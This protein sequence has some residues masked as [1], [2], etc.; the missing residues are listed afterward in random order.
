MSDAYMPGIKSRFNTDQI[1]ENLMKIE[2]V[3]RDRAQTTVDTL[4]T[5]KGYWQDVGK[6]AI[7]LRD[8][9]RQLYSYQNPFSDRIVTS[10]DESILTGTAIRDATEQERTFTVK[11]TAE[12]DRFLS[13]PLEQNFKVDSGS[14]TFTVGKEEISFEFR[15]GTLKE[16]TDALNRRGRD[17]LQSSLVTVKPGTTS[18][19]IESKLTGEENRL[20][21]SGAASA[22]GEKTGMI[23]RVNDSRK[24]FTNDIIKV[25]SGASSE[26]PMN[27]QIPPGG[28]WVLKFETATEIKPEDPWTPPKPPP[29]PSIPAAGYISYGGI[30][31]ENDNSSVTLPPWTAPDPPKHVDNMGVLSLT[32]SDGS[33]VDLPPISDSLGF[34]GYQYSL[35]SLAGRSATGGAGS[36][37]TSGIGGNAISGAGSGVNSD[38]PKTIVSMSI[39]NNNTNRDIN[40]R[41]VQVFDPNALGGIKPLNP[42][43]TAQD[44]IVS[45]EGIEVHR[46][47]NNIS[48]LI[49]GVTIT[50]KTASDTPVKLKVEPDRQ[51]AKDNI[52][53]FV[54]NYNRLI[55]EINVLTRN[56]S[57]IIEELTYLTKDEKDDYQKKLGSFAGDSTLMQIRS[58]LMRIV[59]SP[60]PTSEEQNLSMLAQI[61]IGTDV[62]RSG[63]SGG[64]DASRLR[65]YLEIDEKALD[66]ALANQMPAIKELFASD[67]SG[68]LLPDTGIAYSVDALTKP[69]V[70]SNGIIALK[71]GTM[72]T[73]IAQQK[74]TID[75]LDRQ[76]TAKEADLKKQYSQ[77]ESAYDRMQ[78]M[79]TSLDRFQQQNSNT[80]N[81]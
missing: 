48:D 74:Q 39:K 58:S 53:A 45:M 21:F 30:I 17:V 59:T 61:G 10:G 20:N 8:S 72:D 5:Q 37:A 19:L 41:N 67:T 78:Q 54:G 23:G 50:A 71:T 51:T 25:N 15:G 24:D 47:S 12:A 62:R 44:A 4:Q 65:G 57:Q 13:T 34:N 36:G 52:I 32:F 40:I 77:M 63:S 11:Q 26:I 68:D 79:S 27:F 69:Y 28:N 2:R 43:S 55:A 18:L 16:F 3:P 22:L 6:R 9:A 1:I 75:T 70:E 38:S 80:N 73:K 56:D 33:S 76:L 46:S 29:G 14:Y 60:Y 66:A 42:V 7:A 49:P 64:Y 35:D 81:R 31:V